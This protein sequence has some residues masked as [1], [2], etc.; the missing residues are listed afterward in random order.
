VSAVG[1]AL[2]CCGYLPVA[3]EHVIVDAAAADTG[4]RGV[5]HGDVAKRADPRAT[6][7]TRLVLVIAGARTRAPLAEHALCLSLREQPRS[8]PAR[9]RGLDWIGRSTPPW[10]GLFTA[11]AGHG[12]QARPVEWRLRAAVP[13]VAIKSVGHLARV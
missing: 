13:A 2:T 12:Y 7:R 9:G 6:N 1:I 4:R 3:D 8:S 11:V 10:A 5:E